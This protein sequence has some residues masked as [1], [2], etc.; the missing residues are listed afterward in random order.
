M[1]KS[2]VWILSAVMCVSFIILLFLQLRYIKEMSAMRREQFDEKVKNS[3]YEVAHQ[4]ELAEAKRY[5]EEDIQEMEQRNSNFGNIPLDGF[6]SQTQVFSFQ[7][8]SFS[9]SQTIQQPP[10]QSPNSSGQPQSIE[11]T[12]PTMPSLQVPRSQQE[13]GSGL[14]ER[15]RA[16]QQRQLEHYLANKSLVDEVIYTML[17]N[18]STRPLSMRID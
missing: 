18:S 17:S 13:P 7:N 14:T 9:F 2:I 12:S 3:L 10:V 16:L 11:P 1:K 15:S 5:L 6:Y 8:G 4:L